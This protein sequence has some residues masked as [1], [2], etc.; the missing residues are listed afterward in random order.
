MR[1]LEGLVS[2][3]TGSKCSRV[4]PAVT[5]TRF[6]THLPAPPAVVP[7]A[8]LAPLVAPPSSRA[9]AAKIASASLM[10]PGRSLGPSARAPTSGP[11]KVHPR[12]V[13]VF[14]FSTVAGCAYIASFIAGAAR[15]GPVRASRMAVSRSS[16]IPMA[17]RASTFAVAGATMTRSGSL[18]SPMCAS[19]RPRSQRE[20]STGRPVSASKVRGRTNSAADAV[21]TTSTVA[22]ASLRR[23]ARVQL[24]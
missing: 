23:R 19:A 9:A 3:R 13:S 14:T 12:C 1:P 6:P 5:T 20:V 7:L 10:R 17:A 22:P 2:T 4:G 11:M 16:A 18:A 24:L 8:P 15:T 21:S